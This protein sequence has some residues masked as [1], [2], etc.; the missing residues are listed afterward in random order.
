MKTKDLILA[1]S[2]ELFNTEGESN[3]TAVDIANELD[4]SPGNLYYHYKG[5][6]EII[7]A[8][9]GH[10][11]TSLNDI[12]ASLTDKESTAEDDWVG[13][14]VLMEQVYQYRFLY[15][16][17]GDLIKKYP[18]LTKQ[19]SSIMLTMHNMVTEI[20][21]VVSGT[22]VF[23]GQLNLPT[24]ILMLVMLN[25]FNY[26]ELADQD[27][28]P[29]KLIA[30]AMSR[31]SSLVAPYSSPEMRAYMAACNESYLTAV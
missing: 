15:R 13:L 29:R 1:V 20:L 6:A 24:D 16:N 4:I 9:L 18:Q 7:H 31:L 12:F 5:K 22:G 14:Y 30:D 10:Y 28:E 25:W 27:E 17:P 11:E 23:E 2:L 26:R 8:L 19:I 3:L 21:R